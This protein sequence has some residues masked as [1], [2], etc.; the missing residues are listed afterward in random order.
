LSLLRYVF[1]SVRLYDANDM[2][3]VVTDTEA[4]SANTEDLVDERPKSPWTPSYSVTTL[5]GLS[6]QE[7]TLTEAAENSIAPISTS[8][9]DEPVTEST[10]K[11][12]AEEEILIS[13]S[14]ENAESTL[15]ESEQETVS[16]SS[17]QVEKSS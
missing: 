13:P 16:L 7:N 11:P 3:Q 10:D 4:L 14:V 5:P 1:G 6:A 9:A 8:V 15:V 2:K 17:V 12:A